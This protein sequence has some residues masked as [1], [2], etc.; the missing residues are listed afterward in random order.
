MEVTLT[1]TKRRK[2]SLGDGNSS[3]MKQSN[4]DGRRMGEGGRSGCAGLN[5]R[6]VPL[7][8]ATRSLKYRLLRISGW[9]CA[10][11]RE[12]IHGSAPPRTKRI[13]LGC[14]FSGANKQ[15]RAEDD[16]C[17]GGVVGGGCTIESSSSCSQQVREVGDAERCETGGY[18]FPGAAAVICFIC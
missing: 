16:E 15:H 11:S 14:I 9:H 7:K 3:S 5:R 8:A 10:H 6:R 12:L 1:G 17:T 4:G 2:K 13:I 18:S